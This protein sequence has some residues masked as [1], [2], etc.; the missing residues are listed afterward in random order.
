MFRKRPAPAVGKIKDRHVKYEQ[1]VVSGCALSKNV[2]QP[3]PEIVFTLF[4][5][6][7]DC[8]LT[9]L[10]GPS[11]ATTLQWRDFGVPLSGDE[12]S[13]AESPGAC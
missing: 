13:L 12:V 10:A 7:C 4:G 8:F 11:C 1:G 2:A 6:H 3:A 5:F 9:T